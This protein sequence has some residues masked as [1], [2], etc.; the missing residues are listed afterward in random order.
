MKRLVKLTLLLAVAAGPLLPGSAHAGPGESF[1]LP[2]EYLLQGEYLQSLNGRY[3]LYLNSAHTLELID[4]A[5]SDSIVWDL[6]GISFAGAPIWISPPR[7]APA[8]VVL[9]RVVLRT[10]AK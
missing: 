9:P 2:G 4:S 6:F 8:R 1:M 5:V 10:D 3:Y 7:R